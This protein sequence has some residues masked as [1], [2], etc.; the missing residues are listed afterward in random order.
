MDVHGWTDR[1]MDVK[2]ATSMVWITGS[3]GGNEGGRENGKKKFVI[4]PSFQN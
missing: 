3:D 4:F 2:M 1:Q